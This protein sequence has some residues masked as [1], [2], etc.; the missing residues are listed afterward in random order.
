[1]TEPTSQARGEITDWSTLI[2]GRKYEVSD[3]VAHHQVV[4]LRMSDVDAAEFLVDGGDV[5]EP[6]RRSDWAVFALRTAGIESQEMIADGDNAYWY[7]SRTGEVEHGMQ[8]PSRVRVGP[9][10][11]REDAEPAPET[12]RENSERWAEEE[13]GER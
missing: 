13:E 9:F 4:F 12:L 1:M 7:N 5:P 6:F 11:T 3:G 10:A 2:P 8:S